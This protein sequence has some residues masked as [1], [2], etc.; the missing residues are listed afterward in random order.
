MVPTCPGCGLRFEREE[1]AFLGS[2]TVNYA[3]S[4]VLGVAVMVVWFAMTL[5]DTDVVPM[6]ITVVAVVLASVPLFYPIA[7][8]TWTALDLMMR[9][10]ERD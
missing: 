4:G 8:T 10:D 5:P 9:S 7:K 1:G 2:L 6:M 3:M